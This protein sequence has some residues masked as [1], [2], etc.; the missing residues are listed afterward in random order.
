MTTQTKNYQV[1]I[2][3]L[4]N[5]AAIKDVSLPLKASGVLSLSSKESDILGLNLYPLS[6]NI[7]IL[8]IGK[9]EAQVLIDHTWEGFVVSSGNMKDVVPHKSLGDTFVM[10]PGDFA[11][12]AWHDLRLLI[13]IREP[14]GKSKTR[15]GSDSKY[16][17]SPLSTLIND[18][19]QW[20]AHLLAVGSCLFLFA[21]FWTGL[22]S[23]PDHR[24][25]SFEDLDS[26]YT[27]PFIN[28]DLLKIA[29]EVLQEDLD[30]TRP[31][32]S[33]LAWHRN[34]LS[35]GFTWKLTSTNPDHRYLGERA[36]EEKEELD[37]D[38][39]KIEGALA[40]LSDAARNSPIAAQIQI[41]TIVGPS[42]S[43]KVVAVLNRF[44][45]I[46][47]NAK[48]RLDTK[49]AFQSQFAEGSGYNWEDYQR[50]NK[51]QQN[52]ALTTIAQGSFTTDKEKALYGQ[53]DALSRRAED[54]RENALSS[55]ED[56]EALINAP[57]ILLKTT[58]GVAGINGGPIPS[59]DLR[60]LAMM[61][62]STFGSKEK[63]DKPLEPLTGQVNQS[64]LRQALLSQRME[65]QLCYE[66]ALRRNLGQKGKM[67]WEWILDTEG[68]ITDIQLVRSEIADNDMA[69]C[70]R[71]K[72]SV[73][74]LP[75][76]KLG[77]VKISHIFEFRPEKNL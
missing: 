41:P 32:H 69:R 61:P 15:R 1:E 53:F 67:R 4:Q 51:K 9:H 29:P 66:A 72:I 35:N 60:K 58:P 52:E 75:R 7:P 12:L 64:L 71:R 59:I 20:G 21:A 46:S 11:S 76:P 39:T 26:S 16:L 19:W 45:Y 43:Q 77:S 23:L 70:V 28:P 33:L 8:K 27:L 22:T 17:S 55:L 73:F 24:P 56:R 38:L 31:I 10:K 49:K 62:V 48:N 14:I 65:I 34:Y 2:R 54:Y 42:F 18:K 6:R 3:I 5:G 40:S 36:K 30:V 47:I 44:E 50:K 74:K 68:Q 25:E 57:G 63:A 13:Y 37:R